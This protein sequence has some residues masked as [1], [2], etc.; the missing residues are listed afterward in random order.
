[1]KHPDQNQHRIPQVYLRLWSFKDKGN[2]DALTVLKKGDPVSHYKRVKYF[3]AER[4]LFDTTL[5]DDGFER[6]FDEKC[7]YVETNYPKIIKALAANNHDGQTRIYLT[8]FMSNLFVRQRKTFEFLTSV[9]EKEHLR[10][11]FLNEIAILEQEEETRLIKA[12]Y[13]EMAIDDDHTIDSRVSAVILQAWKHFNKVLQRFDHVILKAPTDRN[14]FTSDN[15]V[16]VKNFGK[17]A[18]LIGPDAEVY[19]AISKQHLV[20]MFLRN[21]SPNEMLLKFPSDTPTDVPLDIFDDIMKNVFI[22]SNPDYFILGEDLGH[23]NAETSEFEN[24]YSAAD[25]KEPYEYRSKISLMDTPSPPDL[26]DENLEKLLTKLDAE[27]EP[28][29][30]KVETHPDAIENECVAI[31][32]RMVTEQGGKRILGWQ[33]WEGPYLMEAEFHVVWETPDGTLK[34]VSIKK[35][36][37]PYILFIEDDRLTYEGKQINNIRLNLTQAP[38]VDDFIET[39]NQQFRLFNKGKRAFLYGNDLADHLTTS[40][41]DNI[42]KATKTKSLIWHLLDSGGNEHSQ[43]PCGTGRKYK[44]C[45]HLI[46]MQLK[47]LD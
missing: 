21:N 15:P 24:R 20:C 1:M 10:S 9:I 22:K 3:T 13:E 43:C 2:A 8:E 40:Q 47:R 31:V 25:M 37:V 7:K 28:T 23:Y 45:H 17:D 5:H 27:F 26:T 6:F 14:W 33:V 18:W 19:F 29:I 12:L 41:I 44:N 46:A 39:C 16:I 38:L 42:D 4:N 32:D 34:D 35:N 36:K 30:L 11:K